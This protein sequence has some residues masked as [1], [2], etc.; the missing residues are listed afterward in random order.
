MM[1]LLMKFDELINIPAKVNPVYGYFILSL[2][3]IE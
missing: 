3:L 2:R 1:S